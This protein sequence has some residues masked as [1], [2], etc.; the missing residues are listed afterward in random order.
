MI[1]IYTLSN[2]ITNEVRY[3]GKTINVKRRYKQ[4]LYDKRIKHKYNWIQSLKNEGLKPHLTIIEECTNDNWQDREKFWITQFDNL[5]NFLDGGGVNYFK[6]TS[7]ETK[8]KI[9]QANLG[10]VLSEDH[11]NKIS[12]S[13][14]NKRKISIDGIIYD[15]ISKA[16]NELNIELTKIHRRLKSEKYSNY[17]YI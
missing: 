4:H 9:R 16:G 1:Y 6:P 11:K 10:K 12:K 14:I 8:E 17:F 13:T 7:E 2:P 15:S 5:I 3:V